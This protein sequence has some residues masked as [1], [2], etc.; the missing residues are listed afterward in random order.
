MP[1][2]TVHLAGIGSIPPHLAKTVLA[3][4]F[5]VWAPLLSQKAVRE[6]LADAHPDFI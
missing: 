4:L 6:G 5:P 3:R 2:Q 1:P